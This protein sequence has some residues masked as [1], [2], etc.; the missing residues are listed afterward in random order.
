M[1][2][3]SIVQDRDP[4]VEGFRKRMVWAIVD[5]QTQEVIEHKNQQKVNKDYYEAR[6]SNKFPENSIVDCIRWAPVFLLSF[7]LF[8]YN[9]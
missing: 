5:L 2:T 8:T 4:A 9:L 7:L 6:K 1:I 3:R